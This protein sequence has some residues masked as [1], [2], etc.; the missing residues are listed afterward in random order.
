MKTA[1]EY[2]AEAKAYLLAEGGDSIWIDEFL[3]VLVWKEDEHYEFD[4]D[5]YTEFCAYLEEK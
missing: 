4:Y 2:K 5:F 3:N 1:A